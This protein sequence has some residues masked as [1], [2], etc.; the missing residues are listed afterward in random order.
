[1]QSFTPFLAFYLLFIVSGC[2]ATFDREG[3]IFK[4]NEHATKAT[5]A[6][7]NPERVDYV[8]Q[9]SIQLWEPEQ[10]PDGRIIGFKDLKIGQAALIT[11]DG[12]AI[13]A[14]HVV[15]QQNV[16]TLHKSSEPFAAI[17]VSEFQKNGAILWPQAP[18]QNIETRLV[19]K[20]IRVI[21][22][23][24]K[25]DLALIHT[26]VLPEFHFKMAEFKP[27][28]GDQITVTLNP[29]VHRNDVA[30][31]GS[32]IKSQFFDET[33]NFWHCMTSAVAR[34]GDSGGAVVNSRGNLVGLITTAKVALWSIK[35][36]QPKVLSLDF[37]GA[38]PKTIQYW[39]DRDRSHHL[40]FDLNSQIE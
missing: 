18:T 39:I 6:K 33:S 19:W 30:I 20:P 38:D 22:R 4:Q 37:T 29:I 2:R 3:N 35:S 16:F 8:Q 9:R 14:G 23:F 5:Y 36:N 12:Y 24:K 13:T 21:H 7:S 17:K 34:F 1:M 11:Q 27:Q 25:L 40:A 26:S 15:D 10:S 32:V 28:K 31:N